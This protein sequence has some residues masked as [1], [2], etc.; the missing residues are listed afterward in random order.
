MSHPLIDD[1][2][3]NAW[4]NP[5]ADR[6]HVLALA[7]ITSLIGAVNFVAVMNRNH[8]A[9]PSTNETYHVFQ[10]GQNH[11]WEWNF[12]DDYVT[13]V[14]FETWVP[15]T[16]LDQNQLLV[17][18]AYTDSGVQF[19]GAAVFVRLCYDHNILVAIKQLANLS[20]TPGAQVYFRVYSNAYLET[21][22]GANPVVP[23]IQRFGGVMSD[24]TQV[25]AWQNR[26]LSLKALSQGYTQAF[27]NGVL[28]DD[29][30]PGSYRQLD[31][32][33]V[34]YDASFKKVVDFPVS[35]LLT[36]QSTK[37]A[38]NKYLL[39]PP[40]G[41]DDFDVVYHDD[42][43]FYVIGPDARGIYLHRNTQDAVRMV[44]H[45][46]YAIPVTYLQ[47][48]ITNFPS[49]LNVNGLTI[50]CVMRHGG[51]NNTL[52]FEANRV[53]ELYKLPDSVVLGALTGVNAT[54]PEWTAASLE[55]SWYNTLLATP[56]VYLTKEIVKKAYGYNAMTLVL[57]KGNELTESLGIGLVAPLAPS[58]QD[59]ATVYE[60]DVNGLYLG[61]Q[62]WQGGLRYLA[63]NP[64]C[65]FV[66]PRSGKASKTLSYVLGNAQVT[67]K[68]SYGYR[69]YQAHWVEG[70]VDESTWVDVT[71]DTTGTIR[72][73]VGGVVTWLHNTV[74]RV[75]LVL[76]NDAFLGYDFALDYQDHSLTFDVTHTWP[77]GG[78]LT[79]F[80]FGQLEL[81]MNQYSLIPDMDYYVKWPKVVVVNK[82]FLKD[83]VIPTFTLRC[84]GFAKAD[85]TL[86]DAGDHGFVV[87][88]QVSNNTLYNLHDDR[89]VRCI[90]GGQVIRREAL[91]FEEDQTKPAL[92]PDLWNGLPYYVSNVIA[93][94]RDVEDYTTYPLRPDALDLDTR[95]SAYLDAHDPQ[96]TPPNPAAIA[97][98]YTLYSPFLN[99]LIFDIQLG[100]LVIPA[101]GWGSDT[102]IEALVADYKW[103]LAFDPC[104]KDLDWTYVV[105]H[106]HNQY[107][108]LSVSAVAYAFLNRVI[109]LYLNNRVQLSGHLLIS[110]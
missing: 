81:V 16:T 26:Y 28:V 35:A 61:N 99:K 84:T 80:P 51:R 32:V 65:V 54:L 72:S 106:P 87:G 79:V 7:R 86:E 15:L 45:R 62:Y 88:N 27:V 50:R 25:L 91:V 110:G 31:Y 14:P 22:F 100:F 104:L 101:S 18:N 19:P 78:L 13:P 52:A 11:P 93:S 55:A 24:P 49:W 107:A 102:A 75:G 67:L 44:T 37:D 12:G 5:Q 59:N 103:W 38:K 3:K 68:P 47:N 57:A 46:D 105:I 69:L 85:L 40:R 2:L 10:I 41:N 53:R 17:S 56:Y 23:V 97:S 21:A 29:F 58:L 109:T 66:E 96:P 95:L 70:V 63:K 108:V 34:R 1:A 9:L 42:C 33:D 76:F 4:A 64:A 90:V 77:S 83:G 36:F 60:Y 6:Q 39:H 71:N 89:T 43:D 94:C 48:V 30:P 98:K 92:L 74:R 8:V 82:E 20:V 73:V